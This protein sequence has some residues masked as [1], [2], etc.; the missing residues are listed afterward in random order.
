[1]LRRKRIDAFWLTVKMFVA[2]VAI[3]FIIRGFILIPVP[4]EGNSM[5]DTLAQGDM[6]AMERITAFDRFDIIVFQQPDGI[7]I[8]RIVGLPGENVTYQEDQLYIDGEPVEEPFLSSNKRGDDSNAP[9]T[10]DFSLEQLIGS[11]VL[12]EDEYFVLGDNRR[13]SKDGRSF[14]A[15]H[16]EDVMGK[17]RMV[18][19][20]LDHFQIVN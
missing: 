10:T 1:M 9:Y 6:V 4:V 7:F 13:V 19:Y 16:Y 2:S 15:I 18:Y 11:P 5:N 14:G 8:K 20:P 3:I 17:V 12:G